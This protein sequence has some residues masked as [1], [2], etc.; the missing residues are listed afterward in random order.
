[1]AGTPSIEAGEVAWMVQ[2]SIYFKTSF[3]EV[4]AMVYKSPVPQL[5]HSFLHYELSESDLASRHPD[6]VGKFLLY[7]LKN[8]LVPAYHLDPILK[9]VDQLKPYAIARN[10]LLQICEELA[11]LGYPGAAA[12]KSSILAGGQPPAGRES[13]QES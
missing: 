12:L 6:A 9:I 11:A 7:L 13:K 3:A 1:M 4:A 2:W 5:E 10:E 8:R